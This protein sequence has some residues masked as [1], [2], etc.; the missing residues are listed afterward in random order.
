MA[1]ANNKRLYPNSS[2]QGEPI[3]FDIILSN[4]SAG[5]DFDATP[6]DDVELPAEGDILVFYGDPD[7]PCWVKFATSVTAPADQTFVADLTYI[8][9]GAVK[10][11]DRNGAEQ[12]SVVGLSAVVGLLVVEVVHSYNSVA[13]LTQINRP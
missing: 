7:S 9:A 5:I 8:P 4:A 3:P 6:A 2:I 13:K 11:M 10:V 12:I 1:E